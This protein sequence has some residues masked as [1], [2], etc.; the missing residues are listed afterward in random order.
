MHVHDYLSHSLHPLHFPCL[1]VEVLIHPLIT[2]CRLEYVVLDQSLKGQG[3]G[4]GLPVSLELIPAQP[5]REFIHPEETPRLG[6]SA[7]KR[8]SSS[9]RLIL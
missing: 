5:Y 7:V 6:L 2:L 3:I 8:L 9:R 4:T 1:Q